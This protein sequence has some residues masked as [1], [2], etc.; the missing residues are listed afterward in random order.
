MNH[1]SSKSLRV[2]ERLQEEGV[3]D[4]HFHVGPELLPRRYDVKDLAQAARAWNATL[5]LK[6]HTYPTT[7]LASYARRHEGVRLLGGTVLN[8][9]VGGMNPDAVLSAQSGN[10]TDPQG[11]REEPTF[12]VWMP[13][14][15]AQAHLDSL[16]FAFDPRWGG[17]CKTCE[18]SLDGAQPRTETAV[19]VFDE[20]GDP[21]PELPAVLEAIASVKARLATGHL[22]AA[23]VVKLVPMALE[24]GIPAVILTHPHFPSIELSDDQLCAL[25]KDERVFIEHCF[26]IHTIEEVPLARFAESI[27]HTGTDQVILS[28]DFGQV[29]SDPFPDGTVRFATAMGDA[30]PDRFDEAELVR[31]F[32]D[33]PRRALGLEP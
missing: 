21:V 15:H 18:E 19:A 12:V 32:C 33:N 16:G 29:H 25:V 31:L 10:R 20:N 9:F 26:A 28:T 14:V 23:E 8:R 5:V 17:G 7:P 2:A 24:A 13:T 3:V 30:W 6:N 27:E 11:D 22:S 4:T 1:P